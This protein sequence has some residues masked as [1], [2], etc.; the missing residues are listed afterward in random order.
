M[1]NAAWR[2]HKANGREEFGVS[3][4]VS[5]M[6]INSRWERPERTAPGLRRFRCQCGKTTHIPERSGQSAASIFGIGWTNAVKTA[7]SGIPAASRTDVNRC[8]AS[9][10]PYQQDDIAEGTTD[11]ETLSAAGPERDDM[12][13]RRRT[14]FRYMH[15]TAIALGFREAA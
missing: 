7:L 9:R 8:L 4:A 6:R 3:G 13:R 11:A 12:F 5:G 2:E 10:A 14:D 1:K 15:R